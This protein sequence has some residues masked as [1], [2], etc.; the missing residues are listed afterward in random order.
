MVSMP[1]ATIRGKVKVFQTSY[2][3]SINTCCIFTETNQNLKIM[4]RFILL[5]V[6]FLMA[7]I[8]NGCQ[9]EKFDQSSDSVV[10]TPL[11]N[12]SS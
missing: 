11:E 4:K 10:K 3:I 6:I 2:L 9:K 12:L 7:I 1:F 8:F 5:T